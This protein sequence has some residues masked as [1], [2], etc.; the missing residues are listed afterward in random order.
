MKNYLP[1]FMIALCTEFFR[2]Q[3]TEQIDY[4]LVNYY[5]NI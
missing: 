1:K 5:K 3:M 2:S 4:R